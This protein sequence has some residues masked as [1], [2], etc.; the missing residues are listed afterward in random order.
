M[1]P[2]NAPEPIA[3]TVSEPIFE[4]IETS[5]SLPVY[6]V[7]TPPDEPKLLCDRVVGGRVVVGFVA[8]AFFVV[9]SRKVVDFAV[10][11]RLRVV[12]FSVWVTESETV[13]RSVLRSVD[14]ETAVEESV[15]VTFF[16]V[17]E[18]SVII[19]PT[20]QDS[21]SSNVAE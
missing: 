3:V 17:V 1:F 12:D 8:V 2:A 7:I 4:G 11:V 20:V 14:S 21:S 5:A 18:I 6:S 13:V 9:V 16:S 10:V 19:S 15:G